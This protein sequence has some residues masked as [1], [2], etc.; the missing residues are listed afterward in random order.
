[1]SYNYKLVVRYRLVSAALVKAG[2]GNIVRIS[3]VVGRCFGFFTKSKSVKNTDKP[4]AR[5]FKL[6][7]CKQKI[8]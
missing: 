1:M 8:E 4:L 7:I 2:S 5:L 3:A 6:K